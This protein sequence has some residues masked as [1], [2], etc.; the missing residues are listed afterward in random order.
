MFRGSCQAVRV[1]Q[2]EEQTVTFHHFE[3]N[4]IEVDLAAITVKG[5][6]EQ[7]EGRFWLQEKLKNHGIL[8]FD[9]EWPSDRKG[10][11]NRVALMQFA[12]E[13]T[14]LLIRTHKSLNWLPALVKEVLISPSIRKVCV[15]HDG[16]DRQKLDSTFGLELAGVV[17]L[18]ELADRKGFQGSGLKTLASECNWNM[19]KDKRISVSDWA[20]DSLSEDQ[21][22]YAAEDAYFTYMMWL[23]MSDQT[24]TVVFDTG[25][26]YLDL[27]PGWEEQGIYKEHDGL[28]C[29]HCCKGPVTTSDQMTLHVESKGHLLK[30]K[31][32]PTD[33]ELLASVIQIPP[34]LAEQGIIAAGLDHARARPGELHCQLCDSGPFHNISAA[35]MHTNG[36]NHRQKLAGTQRLPLELTPDLEEQGIQASEDG[37]GLVC[38]LCD[39]GPFEDCF[40]AE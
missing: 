15:G 22:I 11:N 4:I 39:A 36:R 29:R 20:A 6:E 5:K 33:E 26:G 3:G 7:F 32:P 19:K 30:I 40:P 9:M 10:S 25:D 17:D 34:E 24:D 31:K 18:I 38:K 27:R 23:V 16:N 37:T 28:Y 1:V 35:E 13:N 8:G 12:D 21:K 2:E 14:A